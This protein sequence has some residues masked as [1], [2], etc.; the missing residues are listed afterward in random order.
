[1]DQNDVKALPRNVQLLL[2]AG[3]LAFIAT[4]FPFDGIHEHGLGADENAWNGVAGVLGAL[5]ITLAARRSQR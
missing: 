3:L 1:M 5:A 4:F 2:G